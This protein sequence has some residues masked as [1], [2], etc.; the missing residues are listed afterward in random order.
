MVRSYLI[1]TR[2][3][4]NTHGITLT[5]KNLT[6]SMMKDPSIRQ[7]LRYGDVIYLESTQYTCHI[8]MSC[9]IKYDVTLPCESSG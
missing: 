4:E 6:T 2:S 7:S 5:A 1:V 8:E 9:S 3:G